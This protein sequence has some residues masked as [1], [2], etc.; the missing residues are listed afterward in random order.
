MCTSN[1]K[2]DQ[3]RLKVLF[4]GKGPFITPSPG[5]R[6][7]IKFYVMPCYV[8]LCYVMLCYAM[9]CYVMLSYVMLCYVMLCNVTNV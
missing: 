5:N 7:K 8:M 2:Q 9:P 6:C 3:L 4:C 1:G